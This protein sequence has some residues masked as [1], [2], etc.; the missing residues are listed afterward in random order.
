MANDY[1]IPPSQRHRE[2]PRRWLQHGTATRLS[3]IWTGTTVVLQRR[4]RVVP[5]LAPFAVDLEPNHL[6]SSFAPCSAEFDSGPWSWLVNSFT[7][8][9]T[10]RSLGRSQQLVLNLEPIRKHSYARGAKLANETNLEL[11][12]CI[13]RGVGLIQSFTAA[14]MGSHTNVLKKKRRIK[15]GDAGENATGTSTES[16]TCRQKPGEPTQRQV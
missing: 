5:A 2:A 11:Y 13:A 7:V 12:I 4:R 10:M 14:L 9:R 15:D 16:K 8:A 1:R 3:A 6:P